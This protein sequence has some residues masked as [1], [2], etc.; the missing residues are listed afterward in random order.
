M[1]KDTMLVVGELEKIFGFKLKQEPNITIVQSRKEIDE[2]KGYK[3]EAWVV[4]F[5]QKG[6][7]YILAKDKMA[8]EAEQHTKNDFEKILKHEIAHLFFVQLVG[9]F[10]PR[11]LNE[12]VACYFA[13][14]EKSRPKEE[15]IY[16]LQDYFDNGGKFMYSLG[17]FWVK[18]LIDKNGLEKFLLFL[19]AWGKSEKQSDIFERLF[20]K[21]FGFGLSE[22]ELKR[23]LSD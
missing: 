10:K 13:G 18:Y 5:V 21:S 20:E 7:I 17:Y 12:G 14:Q 3:T 6:K 11:W 15:N 22:D 19:G 1:N 9:D 4:A 23:V 16:R 8:T 2:I